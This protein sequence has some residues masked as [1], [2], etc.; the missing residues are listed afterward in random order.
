MT[1]TITTQAD[2]PVQHGLKAHSHGAGT[3]RSTVVPDTSR[4]QRRTSF[5]VADFPLPTGREEEWRFTPL[6]L[7]RAALEE[8][9][10]D[11]GAV[12]VEVDSAEGVDVGTL[13]PGQAPPARGTM[14]V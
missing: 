11:A 13:A 6:D 1:E 5:D 7:L 4:A 12:D 3:Y 10:T 14:T 2:A 8:R 9:P